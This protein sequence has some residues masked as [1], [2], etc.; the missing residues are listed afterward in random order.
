M[1]FKL[2]LELGS[3]YVYSRLKMDSLLTELRVIKIPRPK[4]YCSKGQLRTTSETPNGCRSLNGKAQDGSRGLR[5]SGHGDRFQSGFRYSRRNDHVYNENDYPAE[6][7][8]DYYDDDLDIKTLCIK[9]KSEVSSSKAST[10]TMKVS[11]GAVVA[12]PPKQNAITVAPEKVAA[13]ESGIKN[14]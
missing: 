3:V 12:S 14:S 6:P 10:E 4:F 13:S 11:N 2:Q 1:G 7:P 5:D 8:K 9:D